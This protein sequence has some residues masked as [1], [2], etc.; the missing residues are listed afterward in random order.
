MQARGCSYEEI[1]AALGINPVTVYRWNQ[2]EDYNKNLQE[3]SKTVFDEIEGD[4]VLSRRERVKK[5]LTP[6]DNDVKRRALKDFIYFR[7]R[8]LKRLP[9]KAHK[10][11]AEW[12]E[13][14]ERSV[15]LCPR[16]H[17]KSTLVID[18]LIWQIAKDRTVRILIVS[19]S[20]K[21]ATR[22][23]RQIKAILTRN[24]ELTQY[25]GTFKPFKPEKWTENEL[26]VEGAD[27]EQPHSTLASYGST[28]AL[29]GL[30]ADIIICDDI[31][32]DENSRTDEQRE[33][34]RD[35]FFNAIEH[36]LD[37][38]NGGSPKMVTIGTRKHS[39]DLY[40]TL[41][42]G[43]GFT[44]HTEKAVLSWEDNGKILC[45]E[46]FNKVG[47]ISHFRKQRDKVGLR[48]FNREFQNTAFD[49]R[50]IIIPG[51]AFDDGK[52]LDFSRSYGD[53]YPSWYVVVCADPGTSEKDRGTFSAT[54][55]GY[56]EDAP[57]ER[58]LIDWFEGVMPSEDQPKFLCSLYMKYGAGAMKI[59]SNACQKY[60]MDS[61]H[62]EAE[63]GGVYNGIVWPR[64]RPNVHPHFTSFTRLND[65]K[66][67]LETVG[68]AF[69]M[70]RWRLPANHDEDIT[71]T[72]DLIEK[73]SGYTYVEHKKAHVL[74][75]LWFGE[76]E[77]LDYT[78]KIAEVISLDVPDY[79]Y[80]PEDWI[81]I[82]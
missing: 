47:G 43:E 1:S 68:H 70:G 11:W 72:E 4:A 66:A 39:F 6:L 38:V 5:K 51:D 62:R 7:Q 27:P 40:N 26:I 35:T 12:I 13:D 65:K 18:W 9:V 54:V 37:F 17:G 33:K 71:R 21:L 79:R 20:S 3:F 25:F 16:G 58:Y 32:G 28:A 22:W 73:L 34:L 44:V 80:I 48:R 60:L 77:I 45:P 55:I 75:T 24:V 2:R 52:N 49:D 82:S 30:R 74:M 10:R 19:E 64:F 31:V 41:I 81:T 76:N 8:F 69:D 63:L 78:N 53:K 46:L 59:E 36:I 29:Y 56:S 57:L 14:D 61:V 50:D 15:L 67:G 23:V 42:K